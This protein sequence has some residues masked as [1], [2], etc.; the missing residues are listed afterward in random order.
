MKIFSVVATLFHKTISNSFVIISLVLME[1]KMILNQTQILIYIHT[2][3]ITIIITITTIIQIQKKSFVTNS[4]IKVN[5]YAISIIIHLTTV[6]LVQLFK[7]TIL[8][9]LIALIS[10]QRCNPQ[11]LRI[12]IF[13]IITQSLNI[14][15]WIITTLWM[16]T[17]LTKIRNTRFIPLCMN[18]NI[19]LLVIIMGTN[20]VCTVLMISKRKFILLFISHSMSLHKITRFVFI[21]MNTMSKCTPLDM[22]Q[23]T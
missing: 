17:A 9:N 18:L 15:P 2:P 12:I 1:S 21:H 19:L 20:T 10:T 11:I 7:I 13:L 23:S 22:N 3:T 14:I 8:R 16:F 5:L 6:I 4:T